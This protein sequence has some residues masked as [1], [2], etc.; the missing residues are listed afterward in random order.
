MR[1]LLV[2]WIAN[3]LG[4]LAVARGLDL[5]SVASPAHAFAAGALLALVNAIVRPVLVVLTLPLTIATL[6]LF[7]FL[8]TGFCLWLTAKV[9]PGVA[10]HGAM[11][12]ILASILI[13]L[14]ATIISWALRGDDDRR[15]RT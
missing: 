5:I 10:I 1:R 7:Y 8:I 11:R 15:R 13:S 9:V 4:I 2:S 12:A 14:I 3:S 6:G